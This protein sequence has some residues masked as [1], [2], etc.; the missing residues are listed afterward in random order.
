[1]EEGLFTFHS[2]TKWLFTNTIISSTFTLSSIKRNTVLLQLRQ[3]ELGGHATIWIF[4]FPPKSCWNLIPNVM[5]FGHRAFERWLGHESRTL[6]NG[7]SALIRNGQRTS[8][9]LSTMWGYK[10]KMAIC[11][12][13]YGPSPDLT[14]FASTLILNLTD[15]Q[16]VRNK[17]LLFKPSSLWQFVTAA[18]TKTSTIKQIS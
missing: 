8:S 17:C 1:M 6:R 3:L 16:T 13:G 4:V 15:F 2:Y 12:R 10:K 14:R 9:Q 18:W 7:I 5:I 11:K